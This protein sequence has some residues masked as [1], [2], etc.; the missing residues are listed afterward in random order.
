MNDVLRE[1]DKGATHGCMRRL[2]ERIISVGS[3]WWARDESAWWDC[4]NGGTDTM[5]VYA[6][7]VPGTDSV[8]IVTLIICRFRNRSSTVPGC[9]TALSEH[10]PC[11]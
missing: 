4:H 8:P 3:L 5:L 9:H 11:R 10:M 2:A 1:I 6:L 7:D